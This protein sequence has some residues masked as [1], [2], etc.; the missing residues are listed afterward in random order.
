MA[1]MRSSWGRLRLGMVATSCFVAVAGADDQVIFDE[2]LRNGWESWS[3]AA[4]DVAQSTVV[5]AGS[6]A[7]AVTGGPWEALYLGHSALNSSGYTHLAFWIHG[8]PKGGQKLQVQAVLGSDAQA[9]W[10]V[11]DLA[12]NTWQH[13]SVPLSALGAANA[14]NFTGFWLQDRSGAAQAPYYVDDVALIAGSVPP[15]TNG[16]VTV[17]VDAARDRHPIDPRI[18]GVSFADSAADLASLGALVHRSGGNSETRY[19][20]QINAHNHAS[21]WY[22]ESLP[23]S[24][25]T[26]GAAGDDHVTVSKAGGSEAILTLPMI[27]WAPRL[28]PGRGRLA[29]YSIAKYGAQRDSDKQWFPDAGNGV[30]ASD[31]VQITNSDPNDANVPV[32]EAFQK[33]Y[34][35]HLVGRWGTSGAGGVRYYCLDNEPSIWHETHRD[36]HP[37]GASMEEIRD[38]ITSYGSMVKLVDP[39]AILLGPEEFGW[40]GYLYSGADIEYGNKH[41]WNALPDRKAHGGMDY[42][43]W[44]L[45]QL[46]QRSA[47]SGVRL[48]DVFTLHVYPQSGEFGSDVSTAMQLLRNRS[49]RSLWDPDYVD[50]SWIKDRVHL[51]PRMKAWVATY[52]PGTAIGI[53]EYNWGADEHINGAT[54]QADVLGIFGREGVDLATRWTAPKA[55]TPAFKAMLMYRNYDGQKSGFGDQSVFAGGPNP[56]QLA[57][58]AA[59]RSGDHA[60]T[61]MAVNKVLDGVTPLALSVAHFEGSGTAQVWRLGVANTITRLPDLAY[62]GGSLSNSLPAQSITLFVLPAAIPA[63]PAAPVLRAGAARSD[64]QFELRLEGTPGGRYVLESSTDLRL[65]SVGSTNTLGGASVSLL[66]PMRSEGSFYYRAVTRP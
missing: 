38:R 25:A 60:L 63:T 18:Y 39:G 52:F 10:S 6:R 41:G 1:G 34:L 20:W 32:D 14:A 9:P 16:V 12:A 15:V 22:F 47:A 13:I 45:D 30:R 59:E 48:L 28:G 17:T 64:G 33:V 65:W 24:P 37:A 7:I 44:L 19:N 56:D 43:A 42:V 11:P 29:S 23:D 51:I 27:G 35:Q 55:S 5:H 26:P 50:E 3:W 4:V 46:R 62:S 40:T 8:G 36:V 53:T 61:V 58:F 21:D 57:V 31:G 49:T 2:A 54:A 66:L